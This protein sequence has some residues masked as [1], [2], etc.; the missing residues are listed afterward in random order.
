VILICNKQITYINSESLY[1]VIQEKN[2]ADHL[3][4]LPV[5][6]QLR[7]SY[8]VGSAS[9]QSETCGHYCP[10]RVFRQ[11]R[12]KIKQHQKMQTQ[13][14]H[15][16]NKGQHTGSPLL[17]NSITDKRKMSTKLMVSSN[18]TM[19]YKLQH[20]LLPK[21]SVLCFLPVVHSLPILRLFCGFHGFF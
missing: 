16:S 8:I 4:M 7:R 13:E 11:N 12:N 18:E 21:Y 5:S 9:R 17:Q 14:C 10:H 3:R 2:V 1:S 20:N 15:T 6:C 19:S